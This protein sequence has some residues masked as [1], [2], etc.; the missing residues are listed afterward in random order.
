MNIIFVGQINQ[1]NINKFLEQG[2]QVSNTFPH[3]PLFMSFASSPGNKLPADVVVIAQSAFDKNSPIVAQFQ[4]LQLAMKSLGYNPFLLIF[5]TEDKKHLYTEV[6]QSGVLD[7]NPSRI[8]LLSEMDLKEMIEKITGKP[9]TS[10]QK[11]VTRSEIISQE[12]EIISTAPLDK[13]TAPVAEK[14]DA[15]IGTIPEEIQS[16]Q[17]VEVARKEA[18]IKQATAGFLPKIPAYDDNNH[19]LIVVCNLIPDAGGTFVSTNVAAQLS[20]Y[21]LTSSVI[22]HYENN[23]V[24]LN[25]L[26]GKRNAPNSWSSLAGKIKHREE[27]SKRDYWKDGN[28]VWFPLEPEDQGFK[29]THEEL[30]GLFVASKVSQFTFVDVSTNWD[31]PYID[32]ILEVADEI[33]CVVSP[34]KKAESQLEKF[35]IA[36]HKFSSKLVFV[37]NR[38]SGYATSKGISSQI[39]AALQQGS[40]KNIY[41][42]AWDESYIEYVIP[43]FDSSKTQ[44]A[45]WGDKI[46]SQLLEAQAETKDA[47]F[48]LI[49]HLVP[50]VTQRRITAR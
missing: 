40:S 11:Y 31:S 44:K 29:L 25:L 28:V 33:W 19:R 48:D 1:Q 49:K 50:Q 13:K 17:I 14:M 32:Q 23:P 16:S 39:N 43:E 4:Q 6:F 47:F 5:F 9:V 22:E 30:V 2:V 42:N 27:L 36:M 8:D 46:L 15:F 18:L 38:F 10:T 21:N 24:L 41:G 12:A 26:G 37:G 34:S 20:S 3:L 45:E 35:R 7:Y